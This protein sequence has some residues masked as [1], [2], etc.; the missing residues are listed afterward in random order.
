MSQPLGAKGEAQA[1]WHC[2]SRCEA[3]KQRMT[4]FVGELG[5]E[6]A[7]QFACVAPCPLGTEL[8]RTQHASDS[9]IDISYSCVAFT[10]APRYQEIPRLPLDPSDEARSDQELAAKRFAEFRQERA[11]EAQMLATTCTDPCAAR[12]LACFDDPKS[13]GKTCVSALHECEDTCRAPR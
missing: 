3:P 7:Y 1:K 13:S 9:T 10:P 12:A 2:E 5:G 4:T 8:T 6:K 11:L